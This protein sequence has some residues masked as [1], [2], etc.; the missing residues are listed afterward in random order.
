MP[1][2]DLR[3][4]QHVMVDDCPSI[5]ASARQAIQSQMDRLALGPEARVWLYL[6][7]RP[8]TDSE[9]NH[10]LSE[11]DGFTSQWQSH[12]TP[13]N[14][15]ATILLHDIVLLAVDESSHQAT[16]CSI[17][18]S[19][20]FLRQLSKS[21][22]SLADLDL[23]DRSWVFHATLPNSNSSQESEAFTWQRSRLHEF[24]ARCKSGTVPAQTPILDTTIQRLGQP[25]IRPLESSW[26]ATMW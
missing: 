12:G 24:W 16:G 11:L 19:V 4:V 14:A 21:L 13:L 15:A 8:L 3:P 9:R 18:A 6:T 7:N 17:D 22:P 25:L 5:G 26:H 20:A 1:N 2:P 23:M 10:V